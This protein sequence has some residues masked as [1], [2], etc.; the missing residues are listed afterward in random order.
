MPKEAY[1]FS[2]LRYLSCKNAFVLW[3]FVFSNI[4]NLNGSL[5][6]PF[7]E[8]DSVLERFSVRDFR[9]S[10]RDSYTFVYNTHS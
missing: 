9:F 2:A 1:S 7:Q 8:R 10:Y 4:L 5:L 6:S 3:L